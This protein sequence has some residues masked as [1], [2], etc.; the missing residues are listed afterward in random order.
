MYVVGTV[1]QQKDL[2]G[3]EALTGKTWLAEGKWANGRSFKQEITF[4][5]GLDS[6]IV[7]VRTKGF[8]DAQQQNYG[9][10][11]HGIR[12]Y[13]QVAKKT[14]FW[15][16]DVFGGVTTGEV[17]FEQGNVYYTY[18]YGDTELT[19]AWIRKDEYTYEFIVGTRIKGR[20]NKKF[21]KTK[22]VGRK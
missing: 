14:R 12:Q 8:T 9:Q 18:S 11:N 22:F 21:L 6:T 17:V 1:G 13:D 2:K 20:W 15:E 4:E 16:Y 10:R 7:I 19:D 5:Y 3:F